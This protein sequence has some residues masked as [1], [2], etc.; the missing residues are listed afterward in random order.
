MAKATKKKVRRN[1]SRGIVHIKSTFNNTIVSISDPEGN[2]LMSQS[3]GSVG[4]KGSRK[5]T[6]F[7]AQRAAENC[8][9][10]AKKMGMTQVDLKVKGPGPGRESAIR[11]IQSSGLE[12]IAIEDVTPLPHNGCRPRKRRRV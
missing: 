10:L 8:A 3:G 9:A 6:P 5:S 1:V 12:I 11:A 7:A 4:Y 2:S